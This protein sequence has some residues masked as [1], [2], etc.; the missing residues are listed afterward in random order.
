MNERFSS[1]DIFK[2]PFESLDSII[3]KP[4]SYDE[5]TVLFAY[6]EISFRGYELSNDSLMK[7]MEFTINKGWIDIDSE[8]KNLVLIKGFSSFQRYR[9]AKLDNE[10]GNVG[11]A[12]IPN[13]IPS[14][15]PAPVSANTPDLMNA[16]SSS[17][18]SQVLT[19]DEGIKFLMFELSKTG[20][21]LYKFY[22]SI[23]WQVLSAVAFGIITPLTLTIVR[24]QDE[25]DV[26]AALV[27]IFG[28]SI[29]VFFIRMLIF[30][31]RGVQ[32]LKDL[33]RLNHG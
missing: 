22:M 5:E 21:D 28:I 7:L 31:K 29:L 26:L 11:S 6:A 23:V 4:F 17:Y 32:R 24:N 14:T 1:E 10:G 8:I 27:L 13:A 2:M 20:E 3:S 33:D 12:S 15:E 16:N 19:G 25:V 9:E 30:L 18:A